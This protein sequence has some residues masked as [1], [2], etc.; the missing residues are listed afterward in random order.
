MGSLNQVVQAD[1]AAQVAE[2]PLLWN[3]LGRCPHGDQL[4]L[5]GAAG[6]MVCVWVL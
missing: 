2:G 1:K 5:L 3:A 4:S 6:H